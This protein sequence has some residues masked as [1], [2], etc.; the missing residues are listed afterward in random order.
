M[1]RIDDLIG[2]IER[3]EPVDL[4]KTAMLLTLDMVKLGEDFAHD[5]IA[6]MDKE[7]TQDE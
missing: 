3:G 5:M 6:I 1:S 2:Q 4:H 7:Y